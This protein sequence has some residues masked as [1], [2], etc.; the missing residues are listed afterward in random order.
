MD[1]TADG[2]TRALLRAVDALRVRELLCSIGRVLAD[3]GTG[4]RFFFSFFLEVSSMLLSSY[5]VVMCGCGGSS[6]RAV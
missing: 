3:S 6:P 2:Q 4:E 1:A 5:Y